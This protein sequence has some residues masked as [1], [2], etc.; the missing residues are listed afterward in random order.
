MT[1]Q[2]GI[3]NNAKV[4]P[5]LRVRPAFDIT[6]TPKSF[7]VV[8]STDDGATN[9]FVFTK[10][11]PMPCSD[12]YKLRVRQGLCIPI[13]DAYRQS[14]RYMHDL[15]KAVLHAKMHEMDFQGVSLGQLL[16][17]PYP[18]KD[19]LLAAYGNGVQGGFSVNSKQ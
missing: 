9:T 5:S 3:E 11:K 8:M 13:G 18:D 10:N 17:V 14:L 15:E 2:E 16:Q 7:Q 4:V 12:A 6:R 1:L 19:Q